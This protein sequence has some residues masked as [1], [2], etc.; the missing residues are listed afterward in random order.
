MSR[1][2]SAFSLAVTAASSH[3]SPRRRR[4]LTLIAWLLTRLQQ[5]GYER[6]ADAWRTPQPEP[7]DA[8]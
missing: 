8:A 7:A 6:S 5:L 2:S 1:V 4:L 3:C